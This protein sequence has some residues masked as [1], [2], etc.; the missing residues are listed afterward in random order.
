[1]Y[2]EGRGVPQ[3]LSEGAKW[4]RK[5]AEQGLA[6]AQLWLGGMYASGKGVSPDDVQAYRWFDLAASRFSPFEAENREQALHFRDLVAARMDSKQI[7]EAQRLA[8]EWKQA[9]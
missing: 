9:K 6:L 8:R 5:A 7:A 3:D 2:V 4:Y 1:M